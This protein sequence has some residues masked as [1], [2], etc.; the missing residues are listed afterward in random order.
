MTTADE[1]AAEAAKLLAAAAAAL[2]EAAAHP[3]AA[4]A[5]GVRKYLAPYL[6]MAHTHALLA[7]RPM[8]AELSQEAVT[9]GPSPR[10]VFIEP[11]A[12]LHVDGDGDLWTE[13]AGAIWHLDVEAIGWERSTEL[14]TLTDVANNY[15]GSVLPWPVEEP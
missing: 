7:S 6:A 2:A 14:A 13:Q 12:V 10:F 5:D 15:G 8:W 3:D 9:V 1:H 11:D 4:V